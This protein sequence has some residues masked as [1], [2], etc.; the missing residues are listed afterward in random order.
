MNKLTKTSRAVVAASFLASSTLMPIQASAQSGVES[1]VN[2]Q[3]ADGCVLPIGT[4][5]AGGVSWLL[6]ALLGIAAI[7]GAIFILS[8]DD[9]DDD[10]IPVS[11]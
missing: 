8:D 6:P 1:R 7:A 9:D 10:D 11:P 2:C 5:S 4:E 3:G